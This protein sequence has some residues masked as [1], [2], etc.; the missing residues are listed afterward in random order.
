MGFDRVFDC[1]VWEF[2]AGIH[3]TVRGEIEIGER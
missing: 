2:G 1:G 3:V